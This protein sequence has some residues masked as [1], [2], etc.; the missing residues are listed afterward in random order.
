MNLPPHWPE[1]GCRSRRSRVLFRE[2]IC[3]SL[4]SSCDLQIKALFMSTFLTTPPCPAR[5]GSPST[6]DSPPHHRQRRPTCRCGPPPAESG[7][8]L[9]PCLDETAH[10]CRSW[11]ARRRVRPQRGGHQRRIRATC[12]RSSSVEPV[13]AGF[14]RSARANAQLL[15]ARR[16]FEQPTAVTRR[17]HRGSG[18]GA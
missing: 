18:S 6:Q 2:G 12:L 11:P 16:R 8:S 4:M 13:R 14:A 17:A 3:K 10:N 1:I 5:E 7:M 9:A 15:K